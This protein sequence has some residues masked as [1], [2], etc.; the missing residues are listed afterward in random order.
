MRVFPGLICLLLACVTLS[1]A[2]ASPEDELISRAKERLDKLQSLVD[3]GAAPRA[4]LAQAQDDLADAED[5]AVLRKTMYGAGLTQADTDQM[6][7]AAERRYQ[8]RKETLEKT[9]QLVQAGAATAAELSEK[10][11][12]FELAESE[13]NLARQRA[14][15]LH[16][17]DAMAEE[18]AALEQRLRTSPSTAHELGE[19]YD[20]NGVFTPKTLARV[21]NAFA[22]RF[23]KPL[24]IS[25]MGETSVHRA[26]GFNHQGRVDVAVHPDQPEGLWLRQYL[27]SNHIPFFAFRQAVP[28]KATG[29]HIHM[30]PQSTRL[31]HGG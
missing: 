25:A 24:P 28:G 19:R 12:A 17:L 9:R 15:L 21:E 6:M 1:F 10:E 30:G 16:D 31:A 7:A 23:G 13:C 18:E 11:Q 14:I 20:G 5:A 26:L 8:R 27:T 29:A 22:A 4:Q 2:Q 3:A